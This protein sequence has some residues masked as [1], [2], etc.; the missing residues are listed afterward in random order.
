MTSARIL[1]RS[2]ILSALLVILLLLEGGQNRFSLL[3]YGLCSLLMMAAVILFGRRRALGIFGVSSLLTLLLLGPWR[4]LGFFFIAGPY[5]IWKAKVESGLFWAKKG[6]VWVGKIIYALLSL[7]IFAFFIHLG[8]YFQ[9]LP[10]PIAGNHFLAK[11]YA[12]WPLFYLIFFVLYDYL[13][14]C[15]LPWLMAMLRRVGWLSA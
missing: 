3:L 4:S 7:A 10:F 9:F 2:A 5:P 14:T 6:R 11:I 13:L 15:S 12:F 1:S 8:Q